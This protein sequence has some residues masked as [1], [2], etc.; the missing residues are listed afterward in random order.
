ML[1]REDV[2][3]LGYLAKAK[4]NGSYRGMR[5]ML[6][7]DGEDGLKVW[8]WPEPY[9]FDYT[10]EEKKSCTVTFDDE[11]LDQAIGWLNEIYEQ[12]KAR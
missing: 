4:F 3:S 12:F 11:G 5:F 2:L 8:A 7:K 1:K 6:E 10:Q 9:G